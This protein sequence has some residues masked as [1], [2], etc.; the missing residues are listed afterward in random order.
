MGMRDALRAA[1][2]I[3]IMIEGEGSQLKRDFLNVVREQGLGKAL[4]WREDRFGDGS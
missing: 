3:D 4:Q 1:L 2:D